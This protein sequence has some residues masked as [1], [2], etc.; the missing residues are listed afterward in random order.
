[1]S[2]TGK[3]AGVVIAG[4]GQGGF[5]VAASLR[6]EGYQGSITL[7]GD[8]PGRPYQRPPLSKAFMAGKLD[9]EATH[10]RPEAFYQDQRINL[11]MGQ[12]IARIEPSNHRVL[13]A[14]GGQVPYRQLVLATGARNRRLPVPGAGLEGVCYLRTRDEAIDI[15]QRLG[16]AQNI[17]IIGGGFIGLELAAVA[18][19]LGKHVMVVEFKER[20]MSRVVAPIISEFYRELHLSH[21][22]A[23]ALGVKTQEISSRGNRVSEVVLSDGGIYPADLVV[24][25]IGVVPNTELA[26]GCDL[27]VADGIVVDDHMRTGNQDIYAIGDCA[28]HPNRFAGGPVRIE[29]VQNSVDQARCV[30]ASIVGRPHSYAAVPWFWTDQFDIKFQMVGLSQGC[31]AA[32]TRGI[33]ESKKFSVLYFKHNRLVAI[34]SINRPADHMAGRKLLTSGTSLTP[35][36]AADPSVDL[37]SLAA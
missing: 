2:P 33:P 23:F 35:E 6:T 28:L 24:V 15:R 26:E 32:V 34:D 3:S 29:S 1:M 22:I 17:V 8:E 27:A 14:S 5:Q 20:L 4:A 10:L 36:Q 25:G 7:I 18:S 37:K 13:L 19:S 11:M 9:V 30:A 31:D 21:G 16:D 12:R